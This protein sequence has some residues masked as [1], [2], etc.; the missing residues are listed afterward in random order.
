MN[1]FEKITKLNYFH[2]FILKAILENSNQASTK[3]MAQKLDSYLKAHG[4]GYDYKTTRR[5]FSRKVE[6]LRNLDIVGK[7][8]G[9]ITIYF[10][11]PNY[12]STAKMLV[13]GFDELLEVKE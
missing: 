9:A 7:S 4:Q 8:R 3:D 1:R 13:M 10:I 5:I 11:E 6:H 2:M 12:L